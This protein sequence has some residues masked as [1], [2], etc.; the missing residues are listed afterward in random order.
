MSHKPNLTLKKVLFKTNLPKLDKVRQASGHDEDAVQQCVSQEQ[1]EE[2]VVIVADA[3]VHPRTVVVHLEDA[4]GADAA[5]VRAVRLDQHA[6]VA[7]ADG[8]RHSPGI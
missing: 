6:S 4:A 2:L 7:V 5:V 3:V 8:T 1:D